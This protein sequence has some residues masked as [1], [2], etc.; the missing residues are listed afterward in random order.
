MNKK[1]KYYHLDVY[2]SVVTAT[3]D[4]NEQ[5]VPNKHAALL[6]LVQAYPPLIELIINLINFYFYL[7][8][9]SGSTSTCCSNYDSC[10][11]DCTSCICWACS[12]S[13]FITNSVNGKSYS[14]KIKL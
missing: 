2:A 12:C 3:P 7:P 1:F 13:L 8:Y 14:T 5:T 9:T 6:V 4:Y 10:C 11:S